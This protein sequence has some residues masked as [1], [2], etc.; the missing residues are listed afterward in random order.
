MCNNK[1]PYTNYYN[2]V[3]TI[4]NY[5][6]WLLEIGVQFGDKLRTFRVPIQYPK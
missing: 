4:L 2:L 3:K 1:K 6:K 5:F